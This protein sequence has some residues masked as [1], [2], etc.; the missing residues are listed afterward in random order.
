MFFS[1]C[2]APSQSSGPSADARPVSTSGAGASDTAAL[3]GDDE[4]LRQIDEAL[5]YT[6]NHR[7]LSVGASADD[8]AAWQIVHGALAFKRELQISDGEKDVSAVEYVLAG[9]PMKR[10]EFLEGDVLDPQTGRRG[11]RS[12]PSPSVG[13]AV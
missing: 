3:P 1:G 13:F 11:I 4:I 5:D 7:R 12:R 8:Q 6:Y 9:R 2:G 10:L